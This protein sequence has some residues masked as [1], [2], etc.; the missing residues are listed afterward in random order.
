MTQHAQSI[1][2]NNHEEFH[3]RC[4]NINFQID[5]FSFTNIQ[6]SK[7]HEKAFKILLIKDNSNHSIIIKSQESHNIQKLKNIVKFMLPARQIV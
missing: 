7:I 6:F 5:A 1:M 3:N 4:A 2:M